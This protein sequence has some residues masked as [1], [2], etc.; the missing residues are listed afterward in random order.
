MAE[1]TLRRRVTATAPGTAHYTVLSE[2]WRRSF[3]GNGPVGI[4][5]RP[6][7]FPGFAVPGFLILTLRGIPTSIIS[8]K[9]GMFK[10][11][12]FRRNTIYSDEGFSVQIS[13]RSSLVYRGNDGRK[14]AITIEMELHGYAVWLDTIG[15]W[16][17][18]PYHTVDEDE[19]KEI[20][21]RV[22]LALESQGQKVNLL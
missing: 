12:W 9:S 13:N 5:E 10:R 17:D 19:K 1:T 6:V 2:R 22:R 21:E 15:R 14:M 8:M 4:L 7:C 18:D 16:D 11:G 20:A 3:E